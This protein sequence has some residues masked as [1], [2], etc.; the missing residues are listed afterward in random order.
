MAKQASA[1]VIRP[2]QWKPSKPVR[3]KINL[4]TPLGKIN[5]HWVTVEHE[6]DP[7]DVLFTKIGPL[8]QDIVQGSRILVAIYHPPMITK[9]A[10]GI[11][12]TDAMSEEDYDEY[13]WMGKVGL[14]VAMGA[15]AYIDD[16]TTKFDGL[17]NEIG[18][19][20]WFM[21]SDGQACE[22]NE[23]PCRKFNS[24]G[25]INGKIPHPDYVW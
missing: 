12:L 25:L 9:T 21:P 19:W 4:R 3:R 7:K 2:E 22:I 5:K 14:I 1:K 24:E 23:V 8:P 16:E 11:I 10:G 13:F 18:D 6:E 20:V 17:K 15:K